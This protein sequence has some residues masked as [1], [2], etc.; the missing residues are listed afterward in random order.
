M[1]YPLNHQPSFSNNNQNEHRKGIGVVAYL[2]LKAWVDYLT[3][4]LTS[5]DF[6]S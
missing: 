4:K 2:T 3:L 5:L 1:T 6:S